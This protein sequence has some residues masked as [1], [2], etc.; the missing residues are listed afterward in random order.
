MEDA[1]AV[2]V[3]GYDNNRQAWLIKNSWGPGF[4]DKGFAWVAFDAP[5]MCD[6][7]DTYGFVF[8]ALQPQPADQPRLTTAAGRKGCA[9]YKAVAGDYP[10]GLASRVGIPV[11]RLLLDNLDV[12]KDPS[13]LPVGTTLLLCGVSPATVAGGAGA[14]GAGSV[15]DEVAALLA[16]KRVLD[17]PG[18]ALQDWQPGSPSP[19]SWTG[20]TCDAGS[21]QV[22]RINFFHPESDNAK[23]Q[24]SGQLPSGA[25]LRRLPGLV[26]MSLTSTGVGGP[27]PE[28]WSQLGQLE[29]VYLSRN[30]LTGE[31]RV[32][33]HPWVADGTGKLTALICASTPHDRHMRCW[34]GGS[35]HPAASSDSAAFPSATCIVPGV[36]WCAVVQCSMVWCAAVQCGARPSPHLPKPLGRLSCIV[37]TGTLPPSWGALTRLAACYLYKNTLSGPL[38]GTW[39]KMAALEE[40]ALHNNTLTGTLPPSWGALSKLRLCYLENNTL[41]GPLPGA[42]SGM[43][44]LEELALTTNALAGT[45]PPS[46]GA[47]SKLR[48]C[49]LSKNTLSGPL[50]S[51]WSGMVALENLQ[52]AFN[53]LAGTLPPSWG[54]LSTLRV[55]YLYNNTLS[56]PLPSTWSGMVAVED[57]QLDSNALVGTV[58]PSWGSWGRVKTVGLFANPQL[59]GCLPA[60]WRGKVNVRKVITEDGP[61]KRKNP[62]TA[63]TRITGFC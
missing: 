41:S 20:I 37:F 29:E 43:A 16:I 13:T 25:L 17:P 27:L 44:A 49:Y 5:G 31:S 4:A 42:W 52:L 59:S 22:T 54:A 53:S 57:L 62:L 3:V 48:L 23:V 28:D 19:C 61:Y 34:C 2:Q 36:L 56:G 7:Q 8:L 46:W 50:P 51:T 55:C 21:K 39:S 15:N 40:I 47:L 14:A 9:T 11:Q 18:T 6:R 38:P 30:K 63:G 1:H 26:V 12:I 60:A 58:P 10:E 24:L 35:W 33:V 45:L 32:D